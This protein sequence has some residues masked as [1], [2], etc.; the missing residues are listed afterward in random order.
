MDIFR[1]NLPQAVGLP[2][3][4]TRLSDLAY[5]L[6]WTWHPE[7]ARAFGRL[8]YDSWEMLG[9]N[10][11]R[12]LREV[13]RARLIQAARDN[14]Y[15]AIYD[16]IFASFDAYMAQTELWADR[17]HPE[18]TNRPIAYFSMEY[19]LHETL[20]IYSGGLG[21]LAGDHLKEASDLGLPLVGIGLMYGEGYFSQRIT[22]DGW[23]ES[24]NRL[25]NFNDLPVLPVMT[26]DGQRM[27]VE[28]EFPDRQ[29]SVQIW[30]VRVGRVAL[31]L[32]DS[33]LETNSPGD[34][35]LTARLYWADLDHRILQ[36]MLLGIGGVRALRALGYNPSVWHMNEGHAAFLTLERARE[37]VQA[38]RD[39]GAAIESTRRQNVFTTHTPVPAGNDEFPLWLV[40]KYFSALWP[41]LKLER[42]QFFDIARRG[43]PSGETFSMGVLALRN[44]G[45][46]NAVSEL[47][48][49]VARR[50]WNFLWPD[51]SQEQ[52]PISHVTNGVHS[53]NWMARRMRSLLDVHLGADW[54]ERLDEPGLWSGLDQI[55]DAEL[56]AVRIH[57]K[58]KL[59][60]YMRERVRGRWA[61]GGY[62]PVQ[63]VAS[64]VL[65]NPYALTIG[66]ARRFAAYKRANLIFSDIDRLLDI[67]NR[68]NQPVQIIFAGKAHPADSEGKQ[69]IQ[70][71][72]R[73]V[74]RAEVSG[75]LVFLEDY[76]MNL[77][78]YLVQGVDIWMNTPRRP[79][80]ASGTSGMKAALNGVVNFSV[81][82][83]WW[84]EAFNGRNGWAIGTDEDIDSPAPQDKE[85]AES[86]YTV[87]EN[88]IIPQF[89]ERDPKEISHRW[90]G[91][92][93]ESMKTII[94]RFSTRRML[95]EY[96]ERV[97]VGALN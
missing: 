38:G 93:K 48:G 63:V 58:R 76:D 19:G 18:L 81:L 7:A 94:P 30:E 84:R 55:P 15:L 82:D 17:A 41:Q 85:D 13:K 37:Q 26:E 35:S 54:Y 51:L 24:I 9:H 62:H 23:Q 73:H 75:R 42:E 61:E 80:E 5:N 83:G 1:A 97:Y 64:G 2:K 95:K 14:E 43:W 77:A 32:L 27:T 74:K 72:Y 45:A 10:P 68:P 39:F 79:M 47:H 3:R 12:F 50:M 59:A 57:L 66:F 71:V 16:R 96:V 34:R 6:W 46:R 53:A 52:V 22:E 28:V 91:Q 40:E 31:Y 36:E 89:Y 60:F 11:I 33:N 65:I 70:D 56:W 44:S 21:I 86:L 49:S 88:E 20:P 90:L 29:V 69:I 87:L 4:L 92:I 25:L 78:R 8:D 67:V